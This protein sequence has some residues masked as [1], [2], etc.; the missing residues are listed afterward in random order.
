MGDVR[1][2]ENT[3]RQLERKFKTLIKTIAGLEAMKL[4][5]TLSD[6]V[7]KTETGKLLHTLAGTLAEANIL[8]LGE[9]LADM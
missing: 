3:W 1:L 9:I 8:T 4:C 7:C 6:T 2:E 5:Y